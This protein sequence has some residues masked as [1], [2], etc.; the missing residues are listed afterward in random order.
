MKKGIWTIVLFFTFILSGYA[1]AKK[2]SVQELFGLMQTEST[3]NKM[4]D[5]ILAPMQSKMQSQVPDSASRVQASN[6]MNGMM[7]AVKDIV[8][9]MINDDMVALY[10]KY[11][12]ESEIKD[13]IRFYKSPVGQKMTA[14][15]PELQKEMMTIVMTKYLPKLK[16]ALQS[17]V[18]GG[19]SNGTTPD[20]GK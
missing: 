18:G 17:K 10:Q 5:N 4:F 6:A 11:F 12:T 14:T 16:D 1:Q 2:E 8:K 19:N 3:T 9:E 7:V 13:L 20:S 15:T